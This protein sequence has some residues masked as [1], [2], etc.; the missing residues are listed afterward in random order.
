MKKSAAEIMKEI[1]AI[2][3]QIAKI[4]A[5]EKEYAYKVVAENGTTLFSREYDFK[6]F[7]NQIEALRKREIELKV[8]IDTF[9]NKTQIEGLNIS[10]IAGLARLAQ[11]KNEI[12]HLEWF[13]KKGSVDQNYNSPIKVLNID[14]DIITEEIKKLSEERSSLL[15]AIDKTNLNSAIEV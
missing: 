7:R 1:K 15:I 10:M 9:N 14:S 6:A 5:K 4:Q 2:K 8:A 3:E 13:L 11:L 12:D